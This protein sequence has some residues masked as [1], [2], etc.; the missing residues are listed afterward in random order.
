MRYNWQQRDWPHFSWE[1]SDFEPLLLTYLQTAGR[2]DG[3]LQGL[4]HQQQ[5]ESIIE[6]LVMEAIKTSEIEGEFLSRQ[7]VVSS[8]RNNLKLSKKKDKVKDLRAS[9][10]VDMM[11][12]MR[13]T[14]MQDLTEQDLLRWHKS[15]LQHDATIASGRYRTHE[16]PMQI[17]SCPAGRERI[18][19]EA[20]PS[21]Q[22]P[23]EMKRF[24]EWFNQ[25]GPG[26]TRPILH[27]P[28]RAAVTHLYFESIHPF[29]DGNGRIGRA[30]AEKAL[31]QSTGHVQLISLSAAI[32]RDKQSYYSALE[33]AQRKNEIT[34]WVEWF[35]HMVKAAQDLSKKWIDFTLLKIRFYDRFR[36]QL[37][38][39]QL[40][41]ID[42]MFREGVDGF[43]GGMHAEKYLRI[44]GTSK[45]TATRDL[46]HMLELGALTA[47]GKAR[48]TRYHIR[49]FP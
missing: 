44:A 37:N 7:D 45:A 2:L 43:K 34:S 11:T 1:T 9:G 36:D 47:D 20:P 27:P 29:E 10:I 49:L 6:I 48:A 14:M 42:R 4:S 35:V 24:V 15:L 28:V 26:G 41:V 31:A 16:D 17:V 18:H 5:T 33:K 21:S 25:S 23:D 13:E 30:L 40:K 3:A 12:N 32:E 19:F 38:E 39:R 8:I 22:V 46:Q